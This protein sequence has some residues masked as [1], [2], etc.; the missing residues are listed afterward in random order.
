MSAQAEAPSQPAPR[1]AGRAVAG[2]AGPVARAISAIR[3]ER[4]YWAGILYDALRF[5]RHAWLRRVRSGQ[6]RSARL[7]ADAHFLEYGMAL[8]EVRP[9]FGFARAERLAH[10][11]LVGGAEPAAEVV[12]FRTLEAWAAFNAGSD[13]P[14]SVGR[15]LSLGHAADMD[16]GA[17][18]LSAAEIR[19]AAS[20]D[21]ARFVRARR[22]VRAF[23][24]G[25]VDP[26]TI[27]RAAAVAQG[28]PSS[29]NRQTCHVHAWTDR[30]AI[31]R[32]RR[33]QA[34]NRTFGHELGGIAVIT[35]DLRH[36]EH[37][38]ER[39]QAWVDGGLFAMT[40]AYALHAE[41]LG[42]CFLNWSVDPAT[43]RALRSEI[44]LG[45]EHLVIVLMGFG[46]LPE[47]LKVCVSPRLPGDTALSLNPRL[48]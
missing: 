19:D 15:A 14:A 41:G 11:L 32:V 16:A 20:V 5:R 39:Y 26:D 17:E 44:G 47:S 25:P 2:S 42:T 30:A 38:G 43:D 24:P 10:D 29:C 31:D 9:G 21:F 46:H 28:A 22:S 27:R 37:P 1:E 35:S 8:R 12:A 6:S 34:G 7:M 45:D 13:L 36:W 4:R 33:H 40:F 3:T 23:A 18:E 48:P